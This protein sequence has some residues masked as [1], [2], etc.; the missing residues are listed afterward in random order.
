MVINFKEEEKLKLR[1]EKIKCPC[2][3]SSEQYFFVL[4]LL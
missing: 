1:R 4:A 3:K 2:N